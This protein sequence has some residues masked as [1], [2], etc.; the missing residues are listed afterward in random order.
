MDLDEPLPAHQAASSPRSQNDLFSTQGGVESPDSGVD[1][2]EWSLSP[3]P[4]D[5]GDEDRSPKRLAGSTPFRPIW[6]TRIDT[7]SCLR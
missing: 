4:A 5:S 1:A 7:Y 6:L 3:S 2:M